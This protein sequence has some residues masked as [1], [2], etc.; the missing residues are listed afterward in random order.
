MNLL[1]F[2]PIAPATDG[3]PTILTR[4]RDP[5]GPHRPS[6]PDPALRS[7]ERAATC[8]SDQSRGKHIPTTPNDG[9]RQAST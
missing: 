7:H 9:A 4:H 3:T 5:A 8:R 6:R 2:G 1:P